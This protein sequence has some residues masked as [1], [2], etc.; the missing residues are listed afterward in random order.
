MPLFGCYLAGI[1]LLKKRENGVV[2]CS[3]SFAAVC[4]C[5]WLIIGLVAGRIF[6]CRR[7]TC[8]AGQCAG[9]FLRIHLRASAG[10]ERLSGRQ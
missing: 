8:S 7:G 3:I 2:L 6:V 10:S 4:V 1:T 5:V 9:Q